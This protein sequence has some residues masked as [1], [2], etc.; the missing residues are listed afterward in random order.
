[1]ADSERIR[2]Q[3]ADGSVRRLP[4]KSGGVKPVFL[5][6]RANIRGPISSPS[7]NANTTSGQPVRE[8]MR[9][10]PPDSRLMLQPS[11]SKAA[12]TRRAFAEPHWL[13]LRQ[14]KKLARFLGRIRRAQSVRRELEV[15]RPPLARQPLREC[16]RTPLPLGSVES[17]RSTAHLPLARFQPRISSTL[18]MAQVLAKH[19]SA[20]S[21]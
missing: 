8:R 3:V 12:R 5:A 1:M 11:R 6:I 14:P 4:H 16:C 7:W 10:E 15:P 18:R 9:C 2:E 19:K 13:M 20:A 17:R 21:P